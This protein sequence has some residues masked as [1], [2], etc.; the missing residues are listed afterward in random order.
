M[1]SP[2][3]AGGRKRGSIRRLGNLLQVW[4]SAGKDS[5]TGERLVLVDGSPPTR[6]HP[7]ACPRSAGRSR[8]RPRPRTWRAGGGME[9]IAQAGASYELVEA[10]RF[11]E[12]WERA[13]SL[14]LRE[15]DESLLADY[16]KHGR[17]LD[18]GTVEQAETGA[19]RAPTPWGIARCS[20]STPTSKPPASPPTCG[21]SWCGWA[22]ST[23]TAS[24]WACKA[25]TPGSAT[26]YKPGSTAGT[27]PDTVATGAAPSTGSTTA[28]W[29]PATTAAWSSPPC[30]AEARR[31]R[32]L[33]S[34]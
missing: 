18:R 9:F 13:A 11:S 17:L 21:P 29:K 4:V 2:S 19:A 5:A 3:A 14:R 15:A 7:C 10:R 33:G 24:P 30:S 1:G 28:S 23:T 31:G 20:S 6:R 16:H 22:R 27:S 8:G 34:G 25:P 32:P 26:W 12:Q